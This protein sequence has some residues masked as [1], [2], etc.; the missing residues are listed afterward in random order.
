MISLSPLQ[1]LHLSSSSQSFVF[2]F[3]FRIK[4]EIKKKMGIEK[5]EEGEEE[6]VVEEEVVTVGWGVVD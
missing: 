6:E 1:T 4:R 3:I 5:G 2:F